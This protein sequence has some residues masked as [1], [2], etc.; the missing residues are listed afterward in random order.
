M[1]QSD[2]LV[3]LSGS[4]RVTL[5]M[6]VKRYEEALTVEAARYLL[7]RGVT[8]ETA[9]INRLGVVDDPEPSHW[10]Y[11]GMLSIPYLGPDD[12]PVAIRFRCMKD[13]NHREH[14]HGKYNSLTGAPN[15]LYNVRQIVAQAAGEDG[16]IHLTEGEFDAM[17]LTQ[18]GFPAVAAPGAKSWLPRHTAMLAGFEQVYI[19]GDPDEA[20][21]Q[22][23]QEVE[24]AL[25]GSAQ[26][27][28]LT[29]GDVN[30]TFLEGGTDALHAAFERS[31]K[32]Q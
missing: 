5:E 12:K 2:S 8:K 20:G 18:C 15:R 7:A 4:Q 32:G 26:P 1:T 31:L 24:R 16:I 11:Q 9:G 13:H 6:A 10:N 19:W 25:R 17:I 29:S 28:R 3:P 30:E 23:V 21:A 22:F 27:I 14:G